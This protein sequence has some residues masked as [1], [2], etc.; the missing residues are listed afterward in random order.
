MDNR[1]PSTELNHLHI[2]KASAGS[3]KTHRLTGEYMH[4]LFS[5][6][7]NHRHILA[8]TFTNKAT[9]EMKSRIVEQL[10]RLSSGM[11]S[12]YLKD[13][14]VN[15]SMD[16]ATVRRQGKRILETILHDYSSFSI[17]TIDRFFQQ[18]MRAFT[19]EM[20]LAGGYNI[21]IDHSPMLIETVD[22]ML[23]ELDKPEN[24]KLS[25]W[26]LR[27]MKDSIEE[28]RSWKIEEQV[29][30]LASELFNETYKS[31][32]KE[33]QDAIQNKDQL[34]NYRKTLLTIKRD[35]E[36]EAK[37]IGERAVN[38]ME[39]CGLTY[40]DFKWGKGSGFLLFVKFASGTFD[41]KPSNR[42]RA[43]ADN[44]DLWCSNK[45]K[46]EAINSAYSGGLNDCVNEIIYLCDNDIEYN[47]AIEL[48]KNYYTLGILNDIKK[49]LLEL[50]QENN[51]LF[52]S[53]TTELL[54]D[55]ISGA[56]SPFIYEK[57]G[58]R[59]TNYM[60][61]EFQDTSQMQ[62]NN[63][64]PLIDESL[65]KGNFNLIVGD[66]KQSI[67]RFRNSDWRLLEE[68]VET[69][70]NEELIEKHLLDTNWRSD[71]NVVKF[72]N[73]FFAHASGVLQNV[74]DSEDDQIIS[75]YRDVYQNVPDRK[76][77]SG[78]QVKITFLKKKEDVKWKEEALERLPQEIESL[79]EQ[80]FALKDIAVVVRINREAVEVAETLINHNYNIISNEALLISSAQSVRAIISL[81]RY[82]L[83]PNDNTFKLMAMYEYHRFSRKSTPDEALKAYNEGFFEDFKE[84][85]TLLSSLP[86][87]DM[88]E[89]FFSLSADSFNVKENAYVQ[90]FLDI[91]LKFSNDSSADLN[92]FL[93]WWDEE[94]C[95]K[96]LF[97]PEG[98][99][100]IRIITI[101]KSKGLGFGAVIMPF[102]C[103]DIDHKSNFN[104][105]TII[106]CK[107][108]TEPFNELRIAPIKYSRNLEN[109]IFK[110]DYLEEKKLAFI[111]NL[112][113]MYVAF[114]RAKH[115]LI[116]FAQEPPKS[117]NVND[118]SVLLWKSI[119][120][121]SSPLFANFK[122]LEEEF[123]Y[124]LGEPTKRE[125]VK[126]VDGSADGVDTFKTGKWRSIPYDERLKLRLNSI[127]FFSDDGSRDYGKLMHD[128]VSN[129]KT[130][131]DIPEAV[132]KKISEGELKES[133]RDNTIS[134]L[135]AYLSIPK[136]LE[137]YSGKY[138]VLNE[139]QVLHPHTGFSRPDRVMIGDKEVV[140]VDYKFG[141]SEDSK[142]IRQVRR[143]VKTISEMGYPKV[144]GAVFYVKS[145]NIEF[146]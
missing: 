29:L 62:W 116:A 2:I 74:Y 42:L 52:L 80:G 45:T 145:G 51:T 17:S 93:I 96:T 98:Q 3:G 12:D 67:Y 73:D 135:T 58:T 119:S 107:P 90:A 40:E 121:A 18:T 84:Q 85:T 72:N 31:F 70:F 54:N 13:L 55:I 8:V 38:I 21:E 23:S 100:S 44:I 106:W 115:R 66:V 39:R 36:S 92:A 88:I 134:E 122:E 102:A 132:N 130:L 22:L 91:A 109:T 79:L 77:D 104:R 142:Y 125:V 136:A 143:Y 68:Q 83:N 78:G 11:E 118:I 34:D 87:Y 35:Y 25:E 53:D 89:R 82:F 60:I 28:G 81:M 95:R 144:T 61:D 41:M 24:K 113:L 75:A 127:G 20:G 43:L 137:W 103:W 71:A 47:T 5:Q 33:E 133:D 48:L 46:M 86:F 146:V 76:A 124:E 99:D 7:F 108:D 50:Q 141:E 6:P 30:K 120:D 128:I 101:H 112:N 131:A 49:R 63:F 65:S 32:S 97:S 140:V 105:Q 16:E 64:K 1:L 117:G 111:D 57:T 37:A 4:L 27:F 56:D 10:Y 19:R 114:T 69:D 15:F 9:D 14:M 26:L 139:T 129:I 126:T 123:V 138:T 94:G 110:D 59:I